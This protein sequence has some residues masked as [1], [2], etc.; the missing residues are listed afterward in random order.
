MNDPAGLRRRWF[1]LFFFL[2]G[3]CSLVCEIVWLRLAMASFGVTTPTVS[4]VLSVFMGGLALGSWAAGR[5][6]SYLDGRSPAT[7]VRLYALAEL[8]IGCSAAAVPYL[9]SLGRAILGQIGTHVEWA[10]SKYYVASG[11]CIAAAF[12]PFTAAMGATFPLAMASIRRMARAQSER[13]FS[14]LYLANVLGAAA[15]TVASALVLIELLGFRRTLLVAAGFNLLIAGIALGLSFSAHA[16]ETGGVIGTRAARPRPIGRRPMPRSATPLFGKTEK[17]IPSAGATVLGL[18]F[19]TGLTSMALEIVWVRQFTPFLGTV[20]YAFAAILTIYLLATVFGSG[21]YRRWSSVPRRE[22]RAWTGVVW[23]ATGAFAA[24]ALV[25]ADPRFPQTI[26]L[27]INWVSVARIIIGIAP[28]CAAVGF[29]TPALVDRWSL[30]NA[31]RAGTAYALNVLGCIVGPLL[32]SFFLLPSLGERKTLLSLSAIF[33]AVGILAAITPAAGKRSGLAKRIG[34]FFVIGVFA[35]AFACIVAFT[36]DFETKFPRA[37]VKRDAT[38]TVI[39]T[40]QGRNKYLLV[41]GFGVTSL[42]TITKTIAHLPLAFTDQPRQALV[43]CFGMGTS[44]RSATTWGIPVT[45]VELVPA[46]PDVFGYFHADAAEVLQRPG[47]KTMI[48]DGRRFLNRTSE[49]YDVIT[50]DPPPPTESAGTSLLYSREFYDA[51][52]GHLRPGGVLQQ[53]IPPT[54]DLHLISAVARSLKESF[55]YVRAF[56][57]CNLWGVH[58]LASNQPI[59]SLSADDLAGKLPSAAA[60]DIVEWE[61]GYIPAGIFAVLLR[62]EVSIDSLI[63]LDPNAPALTDDRPVNEYYF[64]RRLSMK[65]MLPPPPDMPQ[66]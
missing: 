32:A 8:L 47:A 21:V 63:A 9:L 6:S 25:S 15:G 20:V 19:L 29:L 51:A 4:I 3:F 39:A 38:A 58:F 10:S 17:P 53:W 1:F 16:A 57:A 50:I 49:T 62:Y 43:I 60:A 26:L 35:V 34:P 66:R 65:V 54:L 14:Y 30:G 23:F 37:I 11:I 42:V 56:G 48:D 7:S 28:F 2:S 12:L 59:P 46:V 61:T 44:F 18:L 24:F 33:L 13:S 5:L 36:H 40:G 41:N 27:E 64:L 31:R 52:R 45:A 22:T 55:P